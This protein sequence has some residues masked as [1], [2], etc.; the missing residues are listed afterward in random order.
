MCQSCECQGG[1]TTPA[2]QAGG[3]SIGAEIFKISKQNAERSRTH[4]AGRQAAIQ[5]GAASSRAGSPRRSAASHLAIG[6]QPV[7][8]AHTLPAEHGV[9]VQA[10]KQLIIKNLISG[11]QGRGA[12]NQ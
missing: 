5:P 3:Q 4:A 7:G 2:G 12:R 11:L 6:G 10:L 8:G 9:R 1:A